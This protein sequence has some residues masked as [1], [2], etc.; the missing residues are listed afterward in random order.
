MIGA[1]QGP[2]V[3]RGRKVSVPGRP[4]PLEA[5][6]PSG[7]GPAGTPE[8]VTSRNRVKAWR[9]MV[10][11]DL[12]DDRIERIDDAKTPAACAALRDARERAQDVDRDRGG[13]EIQVHARDDD[14]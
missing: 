8:G 11:D 3:M 2:S 5:R 7:E 4:I 10:S 9:R 14:D 6:G 12:A 1:E 13:K